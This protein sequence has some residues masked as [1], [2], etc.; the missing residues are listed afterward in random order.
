MNAKFL[1]NPSDA[2]RRARPGLA[3]QK[4]RQTL[5]AVFALAGAS[6]DEM[7]DVVGKIL[8]AAGDKDLLAGDLPAVAAALGLGPDARQIGT[9]TG[10]GQAH[11]RKRLAC[12]QARN[13]GL[14]LIHRAEAQQRRDGP[15]HQVANHL[16]GMVSAAED[17]GDGTGDESE[18]C[19][20]PPK[21]SG[22]VSPCQPPSASAW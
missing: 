2:D 12:G 22:A 17:L 4:K 9:G 6:E 13:P 8:V 7:Q 14:F 20:I 19:A 5:G 1:F 3:R 16:H 10:F 21:A 11:G 18:S 15:R